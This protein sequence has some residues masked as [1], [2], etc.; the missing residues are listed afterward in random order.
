MLAWCV[1]GG[2]LV[3]RGA[4]R[5]DGRLLLGAVATEIVWS[6]TVAIAGWDA[7]PRAGAAWLAES[8][9]P[10]V[11]T[12]F[13]L[14]ILRA[15]VSR[16][17]LLAVA[18][19]ALAIA[20]AQGGRVALPFETTAPFVF[21]TVASIV[22]L[23]VLEQVYRNLHVPQRWALK[24]LCLAAASTAVYDVVLYSNAL[25][26]GRVDHTLWSARGY[27]HAL[28][29]P[30]VA[31]TAARMRDWRLTARVSRGVVFHSATLLASGIFLLAVSAVGYALRIVEG[32]WIAVAETALTFA[33]ALGAMV[34]ATSGATRAKLRVHVA[35]HFFSYRFDYRRE[36]LQ[37]TDALSN[38]DASGD[39]SGTT[40]QRALESLARL[41]DSPAGAMWT[42]ETDGRLLCSARHEMA[43]RERLASDEP[44]V[45][46]MAERDWIVDVRQWRE[47]PGIYEHARM[48]AWLAEDQRAW[49]LIPLP[50]RGELLGVVQLQRPLAAAR[51]D[52]EV[53]D[54]LKT[55]ARQIASH[56]AVR[57]ALEQSLQGRQFESFNRMS[58]FVVHDLKNLVAQ[59]SLLL[60]NAERHRDNPE[61]QRDVLETV[62]NVQ[63]RMRGL[64]AQL[65]VGARP[66]ELAGPVPLGEAL[67]AALA[68]KAHATP[69]PSLELSSD[70]ETLCVVAHRDR[71]E[72]IIGHLVQN[73]I[74]ATPRD[75]TIRVRARRESDRARVEVE[76]TGTGMARRFVEGRLFKP[77]TTT[78]PHGMG[79]GVFESHEY[80]REIGGGLEVTSAEGR[81]TTFTIS[82][83]IAA[84]PVVRSD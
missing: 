8:A 23:L 37:L 5:G 84:A 63:Q 11:W 32:V 35:K 41:V 75:G 45:R 1:L 80:L 78:K 62:E 42:L 69:R 81:G 79:I 29:A 28:V 60:S 38:T 17:S 57:R 58:A 20:L 77:F 18:A 27:C 15:R 55:A 33:C 9:R 19:L 53:R 67:R 50:L 7:L 10:L 56:I 36:W 82:L 39:P 64:L 22:T 14:A 46:L 30:L 3:V 2:L 72:R 68:D 25:L 70:A 83:P 49:I 13:A 12:L 16:R 48:P 24:F 52:W 26:F 61:F 4:G 76:D 31:V 21:A 47:S 40:E 43:E 71:L 44:I 34:L 65:R 66:I 6:A 59:L 73:A 74:E 51:L 54:I